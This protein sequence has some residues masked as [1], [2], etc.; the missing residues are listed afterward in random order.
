MSSH[1][2]SEKSSTDKENSS[3]GSVLSKLDESQES[4]TSL[5]EPNKNLKLDSEKLDK[6]LEDRSTNNEKVSDNNFTLG[7]QPNES[8]SIIET[9]NA[10]EILGN[11]NE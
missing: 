5:A 6:R 3:E 8:M 2:S 10:P 7:S 9:Q 11:K 4:F 1:I